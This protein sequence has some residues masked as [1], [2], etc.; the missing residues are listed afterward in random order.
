MALASARA[1][2]EPEVRTATDTRLAV[3]RLSPTH[4]VTFTESDDGS[5]EIYEQLHADHDKTQ[6]RLADLNDTPQS[7]ADIHRYLLPGVTVPRSLVEADTRAAA[8]QREPDDK[9]QPPDDAFASDSQYARPEAPSST[10]DWNADA[11]WFAQNYYTGGN[12]GFF[13]V[14]ATW[15]RA[16]KKRW[17][18]WYKASGFN[19]SFDSFAHFRV[20]RSKPCGLFGLCW[21]TKLN[22]WIPNRH[23]V[24]YLGTGLK[25]RKVWLNGSGPNPRVGLAVRWVESGGNQPP[26]PVTSC[27][28]HN[29]LACISGARCQ[30]GLAEYNGGCYGCGT[31]GQACCKDWSNIPTPG[32]WQGVCAQGYC[33]YPGGSCRQ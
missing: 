21:N 29:Q 6:H 14:N 4:T 31:L 16:T 18:T 27:G 20:D 28:G 17:T 26:P 7:L 22:G 13:A 10:W 11:A 23:V 24:T 8:R 32:G 1:S 25:R 19:Q 15:A 2:V 3:A 9:S 30:A 12:D 5:L 33:G